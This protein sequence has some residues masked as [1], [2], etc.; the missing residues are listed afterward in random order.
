MPDWKWRDIKGI[1]FKKAGVAIFISDKTDNKTRTV[2]KDK[3]EHHI[4]IKGS[5]QEDITLVNLNAP[6]T[7][8]LNIKQIL[9]DIKGETDNNT[10]IIGDFNTPPAWIDRWSTQ[11]TKEDKVVSSN[12][13][14]Q[15]DL[16]DMYKIFHSKTAEYAFFSSVHETF[17]KIDHMLDHKTQLNKL[18]SLDYT[19]KL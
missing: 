19:I 4:M 5:I 18:K 9:T 14:D 16:I 1:S 3:E 13:V 12:T 11:K 10:T 8:P 17:S 15:L 6:N 2:T 7:G